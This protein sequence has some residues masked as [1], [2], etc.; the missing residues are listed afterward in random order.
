MCEDAD[1]MERILFIG[2]LFV[3]RSN[4]FSL[5]REVLASNDR[6]LLAARYVIWVQMTVGGI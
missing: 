4:G 3:K 6:G 2:L 1:R 5:Q